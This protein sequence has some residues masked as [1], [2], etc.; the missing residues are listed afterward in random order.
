MLQR[1]LSLHDLPVRPGDLIAGKYRIEGILGKG[2]MGV[3][4]T[5]TH[6]ELKERVAIKFLLL[7]DPTKGER[8][9]RFFR[10]A[11]LAVKIRSDHVVRMLDLGK[12]EDGLPYMVMEHLVG[13]DLSALLHER[14]PL[15]IGEAVEYI[16][17]ACAGVAAAHALDIIHRDLKPANLFLTT[18]PT[19]APLV[20]VLDF[21]ISKHL[22]PEDEELETKLT[23]PAV[24]LGSLR[25]M[26]PEQIRSTSDVD[27]RADIWSLGVILHELLTG[28]RPF[29]ST[30]AVGVVAAIASDP[31]AALRADRPDAPAGPDAP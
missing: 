7:D 29:V 20:K 21:G 9:R 10:E 23:G 22:S 31:P 11:R 16:A 3:L 28:K 2:G 8:A 27:C 4:A 13:M 1:T 14:G 25:Y 24:L 15:P 30:D 19:G 12:L 18:G 17:Q 26:S 5:A 6:E